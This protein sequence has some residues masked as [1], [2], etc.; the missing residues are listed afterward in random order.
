MKDKNFFQ[1]LLF[2]IITKRK[3]KKKMDKFKIDTCVYKYIQNRK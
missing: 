1:L 2:I 3:K